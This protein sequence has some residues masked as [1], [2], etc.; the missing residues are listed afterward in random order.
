MKQK[1]VLVGLPLFKEAKELLE[2]VADIEVIPF[3]EYERLVKIIENY[4]GLLGGGKCDNEFFNRAKKLKIIS[5]AGVGYDSIDLRTATKNDVIVTN[6]PGVMAESVAELTVGLVLA[7]SRKIVYSNNIIRKQGYTFEELRGIEMYNKTLG[8][9]GFGTIGSLV[10]SKFKKAFDMR[11]LVYDPYINYSRVYDLG[12]KSVDLNT[13]LRESD[14]ITINSPLTAETFHM[15]DKKE[16]SLMKKDVIIVNT[17]RG[18]IIVEEALID[19][20]RS[21]KVF[22]AGL[23]VI[24]LESSF[25][26]KENPLYKFDN[27]IITPHIGSNTNVGYRD[28]IIGAVSNIVDFFKGNLSKNILNPKV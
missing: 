15:I 2:A 11:V 9:I 22:A 18:G 14:I 10:A 24:E 27:V 21:K 7:C 12:G 25:T 6:V 4:D 13:L 16:F 19:A 23:D 28:I 20:I 3:I 26:D 1:R 17:A 8:Q 5:I